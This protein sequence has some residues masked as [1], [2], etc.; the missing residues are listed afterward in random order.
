MI[1]MSKQEIVN[2]IHRNARKNFRRCPVILKGINDLWQA[3]LIDMQ[4]F[5]AVNNGHKYILVVVDCFTK[6][7]WVVAVKT[8]KKVEIMQAFEKIM[9][10]G[11]IPVNLQ[12]DMGKEF[13][14][15]VFLQLTKAK[16][17][18]HYST[19]S[20]KKASIVERLIRTL[21][22]KL[23]KH[24][25]LLGNYKWI[26]KPLNNIVKTYN[27]T[28]HRTT[29]FK[30]S[31]VN[32]TNEHVVRENILKIQ[33]KSILKKIKLKIGDCVRISKHKS[34]FK[35]GFTPNWSTEL[36][37]IVKVKNTTPVTYHI[38]DSYKNIILGSFYE[39]EL[40]KT[41]HPDVYLIEKIIR[42]KGNKL[43]VKWLGLS[44]AENSWIHKNA[45]V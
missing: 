26:G 12:T 8:K 24:F 34:A 42:R 30:P 28:V 20:T 25:S 3:D 45:L 6:Y 33:N 37:K 4:K 32:C 39:Q 11:H 29:K 40:Q 1:K 10:S 35:K 38:E 18:N 36:F 9:A 7:A 15:D 2:E 17:I 5:S 14:N 27:E 31:D 21:K 19:Y 41:C 23:Y 43:F 22:G 13:Y 44:E 16:H